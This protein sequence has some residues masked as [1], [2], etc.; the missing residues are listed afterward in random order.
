M[1][2]PMSF[3]RSVKFEPTGGDIEDDLSEAELSDGVKGLA[4]RGTFGGVGGARALPLPRMRPPPSLR[5]DMA[6]AVDD[7]VV[8]REG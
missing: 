1:L 4:A 3:P 7:C 2:A 5:P 6:T 8:S